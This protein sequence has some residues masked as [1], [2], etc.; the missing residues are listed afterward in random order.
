M[1]LTHLLTSMQNFTRSAQGNPSGRGIKRKRGMARS[2][3][4]QPFILATA[5]QQAAIGYS[6]VYY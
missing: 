5:V 4:T 2:A 1:Y 6:I 3:A